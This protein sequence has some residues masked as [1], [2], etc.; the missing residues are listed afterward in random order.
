[1]PSTPLLPLDPAEQ[2]SD[3][4]SNEEPKQAHEDARLSM[5]PM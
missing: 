5:L 2:A 3:T 1:L 4:P